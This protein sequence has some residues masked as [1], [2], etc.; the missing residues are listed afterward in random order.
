MPPDLSPTLNMLLITVVST[1]L[2]HGALV[3][4][5]PRNAWD[6]AL[7]KDERT[8]VHDGSPCTNLTG[9]SEGCDIGQAQYW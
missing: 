4:P 8:P 5:L 1:V 9:G 7:P 2:G 3:H 6:R